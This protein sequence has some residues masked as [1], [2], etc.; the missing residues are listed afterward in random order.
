MDLVHFPWMSSFTMPSV[1]EL[2]L[3]MGMNCY[4]CPISSIAIMIGS[5]DLVLCNNPPTSAS[6]ADYIT[7]F[8]IFERMRTAPLDLLVLLNLCDTNK[9]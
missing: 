3:C 6:Y 5:P 2:S 9:K 7:F 4:G 1:I 8:I